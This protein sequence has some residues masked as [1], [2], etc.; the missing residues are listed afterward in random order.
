MLTDTTILETAEPTRKRP[1]R[2]T[3][4]SFKVMIIIERNISGICCKKICSGSKLKT[5]RKVI[6]KTRK[7]SKG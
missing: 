2:Y 5:L 6:G 4:L 1:G 3:E 7:N